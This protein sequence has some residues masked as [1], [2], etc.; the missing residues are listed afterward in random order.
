MTSQRRR[1][2]AIDLLTYRNRQPNNNLSSTHK[3]IAAALNT[4][5]IEVVDRIA[6]HS[7]DVDR[8]SE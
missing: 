6:S 5:P 3:M 8:L 1:D 2:I 4:L 7:K